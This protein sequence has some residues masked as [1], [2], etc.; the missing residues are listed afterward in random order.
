MKIVH[1]NYFDNIGGSGRAAYR[2]HHALRRAGVESRMLV[3]EATSSDWTVQALTPQK[4]NSGLL[5]RLRMKWFN[6]LIG[7]FRTAS[8]ILHS[9]DISSSVDVKQINNSDA[10]IIHLHWFNSGMLSIGDIGKI[11]K[12]IIWTLHDM[13][14]FCGAE[15]VTYEFRWRD[16]YRKDNRPDYESGFDLNRWT[17]ERKCKHWKHPMYIVTPSQWLSKCVQQSVL[18]REWPVT[19]IPNAIDTDLWQPI[20]KGLARQILR[21]SSEAPLIIFGTLGGGNDPNKGF[22][23]LRDTLAHL[24][25]QVAGLE[26]VIFG[27]DPP[28][29][30]PDLGFP[31]HYAGHLH[32]DVSLRLLYSAADLLVIPS[33]LENLPNTGVEAHACGTPVVAFN[34]GGLS[35]IVDHL[36]TGHLAKPYD[37]VDLAQGIKWVLDKRKDGRLGSQARERAVEQFSENLIAEKYLSI[38]KQILS[39]SFPTNRQSI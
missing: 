6:R 28:Q 10:D 32:D 24:R 33:R 1:I 39:N 2:I 22:D 23:L 37:T 8:P 13:W 9:P 18:M 3:K 31:V 12:P 38:Y 21:F 29:S 30:P 7:Q 5:Y 36:R 26:L 27:Q 4:Q 11:N 25:G 35:D 19:V 15:H 17:W 20:E 34:I 14:A 16:E